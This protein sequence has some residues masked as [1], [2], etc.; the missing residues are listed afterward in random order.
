M[1]RRRS[2]PGLWFTALAAALVVGGVG[3][4]LGMSWLLTDDDEP[5]AV[6]SAPVEPAK[7]RRIGQVTVDLD[8]ASGFVPTARGTDA[9]RQFLSARNL[10]LGTGPNGSYAGEVSAYDPGT[11]DAAPL[12]GGELVDVLGRDARYVPDYTFAAFS[13]SDAPHRGPA[14]GWQDP[15]GLWLLVYSAPGERLTRADLTRLAE[16][17]TLPPPRDLRAPFRLGGVPNGLSVTYVWSDEEGAGRRG[18]VGLSDPRRKASSAAVYDGVPYGV[19]VSVSAAAPDAEWT[20]EKPTL[21][22][23]TRIGGHT[24][25]YSEGRN[26]LSPEGNGSVLVVETEHCVVRIRTA[27]R[28]AITRAELTKMV[29]DMTIG[30]CGEPDT[31]I[32]PLP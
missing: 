13:E 32:T 3:A 5:A 6:E 15:S 1:R 8:I 10:A 28:R 14:L 30:D 24:A 11:F 18:T 29:Q 22:G 17:I 27:D 19:T 4:G 12:T 16:S 7:A 31:W 21:T 2:R 25:W 23:A 26:M 20:A 9:G